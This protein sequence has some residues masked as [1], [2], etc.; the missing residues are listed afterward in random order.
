MEKLLL[1]NLKKKEQVVKRIGIDYKK[2]KFLEGNSLLICED[3]GCYLKPKKD[4]QYYVDLKSKIDYILLQ[5]EESL[6]DFI[7]HEYFSHKSENWWI[8]K[9]SKSTYYRMKHKAIDA[10]LEWWYA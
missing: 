3:E 1:K 5:I 2:I 4:M 10:F 9:Y 6:S 7:Y 8:Y